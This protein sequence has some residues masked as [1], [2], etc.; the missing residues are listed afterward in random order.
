MKNIRFPMLC[1]R[2]GSVSHFAE[3]CKR[4]P[5]RMGMSQ[6]ERDHLAGARADRNVVL[7]AAAFFVLALVLFGLLERVPT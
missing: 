3:D 5:A 2:C 7:L 1:T 4:M 6:Q